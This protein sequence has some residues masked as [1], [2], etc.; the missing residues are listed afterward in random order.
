MQYKLSFSPVFKL[1]L[2]RLCSFLTRKYS[3]D[4]A[5]KTKHAIQKGIE[6]KLLTDPFVGPVCD[7]LLDLGV[8]GYRQ[9]IIDKHN[10]V[11][12]NV[13]KQHQK[14]IVLLVFDSRQSIEKLLSDVN[15]MI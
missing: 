13:D 7:R 3:Q 11:I 12:Y 10:L 14:I 2:K 4:L 9:L 8:A 1:T 15:L 5:S 6:E